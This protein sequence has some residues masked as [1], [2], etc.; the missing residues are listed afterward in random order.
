MIFFDVL[1]FLGRVFIVSIIGFI[2]VSCFVWW[3]EWEEVTG[4]VFIG[5]WFILVLCGIWGSRWKRKC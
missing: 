3:L 5:G 1:V 2:R 4:D